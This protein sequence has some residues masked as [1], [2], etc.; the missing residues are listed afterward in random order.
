MNLDCQL[1]ICDFGSAKP[2]M[3][4]LKVKQKQ[5]T[6]YVT[7]R[8][9]RAPELLLSWNKYTTAVDMWS[10]GCILAELLKRRPLFPGSES[11]VFFDKKIDMR[12]ILARSQV[13]LIFEYIGTPAE[14]EIDQIPKA[15]WKKLVKSLPKRKKKEFETLFPGA[16]PLGKITAFY[17]RIIYL[18]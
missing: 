4:N 8:W 2:I 13:E 18:K 3:P 11:K 10:V 16:N 17:C 12:I 1:K 15:R 6:D 5:Y 14:E 7:T 9:Y